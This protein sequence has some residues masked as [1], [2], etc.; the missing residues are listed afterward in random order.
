MHQ[1]RL[2][3]DQLESSFAEELEGVLVDT[4]LIMSQKHALSTKKANSV[5]D[6]IRRS[7]ASRPRDVILSLHSAL[8][9]PHWECW[10]LCWA[11]QC[12]RDMETLE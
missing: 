6:C 12:K 10:V 4:K 2:G 9:R 8:L 7:V 5:Q 11:L 1:H 3:A